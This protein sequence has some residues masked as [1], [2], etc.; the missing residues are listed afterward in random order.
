MPQPTTAFIQ[1]D[2]YERE[3][4]PEKK[5]KL[6]DD[7]VN[8]PSRQSANRADDLKPFPDEAPPSA[9]TTAIAPPAKTLPPALLALVT[10]ISTTLRN[11]FPT[12]PPHT[13]QRF[14]EL[15]LYPTQHYRTLPSYLRALDRI[16]SVAS[17]A[18][19][20]PLPNIQANGTSALLNGISDMSSPD[21]GED[22]DFIG[23]AEL[24]EIP[25]LRNA[26]GLGATNV[27]RNG[28]ASDLR[29]ESTSVIDG[30]RGVGSV[31][32]VTVNVNG[33]SGNMTVA[34]NVS[35][36][37][38]A[39]LTA[40]EETTSPQ[41]V[42]QGELLRQEQEAGVVPVPVSSPPQRNSSG[43]VT[44]ASTAASQAAL[45]ATGMLPSTVDAENDEDGAVE[46]EEKVHVRGPGVIGMEDMGPQA[47]GSGL[48][49]GI[50]V[51]GALGRRGEGEVVDQPARSEP[52]TAA[53]APSPEVDG[54]VPSA[55]LDGGEVETGTKDEGQD[56]DAVDDGIS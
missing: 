24:T 14:A 43:R 31:E 1:K 44:R 32:T 9:A 40:K 52:E 4:P 25:W 53:V 3:G 54:D 6:A 22:T 42:T 41:S 49:R 51:E 13:A 20:F 56:V 39:G 5:I 47:P 37:G 23:G 30:P 15:L 33:L 18:S 48:E 28:A 7:A 17:P 55:P 27:T 11:V 34:P 46:E 21:K 50:D 19:I 2:E 45:R 26:E 10:S 36:N 29:T 35:S 12:A 16:V 38:P 8:S